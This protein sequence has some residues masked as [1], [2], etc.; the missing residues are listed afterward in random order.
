MTPGAR[1]ATRVKCANK[2]RTPGWRNLFP[3]FSCSLLAAALSAG[4]R[5]K[6]SLDVAP[7]EFAEEGATRASICA[8]DR[9][10]RV[11]VRF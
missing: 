7:L 9:Q 3:L 10:A 1:Q 4:L 5:A 6:V 2:Q 11:F 8:R